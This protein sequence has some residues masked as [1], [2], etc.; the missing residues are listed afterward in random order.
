MSLSDTFN[1]DLSRFHSVDKGAVP[2]KYIDF[3]D[4]MRTWPEMRRQKALSVELLDLSDGDVAIDIGCG[5]GEEAVA[6]LEQVAPTGRAYGLDN[7]GT[8]LT[9]ARRRAGDR[10][11]LEFLEGSIFE[12]PFEDATFDAI[13]CERLLE[14]LSEP[15]KAMDEMLRVAKPGARVV[16]ISPDVDAQI[17][18]LPSKELTRRFVHHHCDRR[19]NGW[20]GRQ[21]FR[22][23]HTCGLER[24]TCTG[25]L[26]VVDNPELQAVTIER[27]ARIA[28]EEGAINDAEL[29]ICTDHVAEIRKTGVALFAVAHFLVSG[30]VP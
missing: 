30:I 8:M 19:T 23:F 18:E 6:M 28:H 2:T 29:Q 16:C 4:W 13:R 3:I 14:H 5:T 25:F 20:A 9:E 17:F 27:K 12:L 7:S 22:F 21:L 15:R 24:V 1:A 11:G 26:H 10:A